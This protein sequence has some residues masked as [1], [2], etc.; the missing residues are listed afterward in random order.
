MVCIPDEI[1]RDRSKNGPLFHALVAAF[2][3]KHESTWRNFD[4]SS[5]KRFDDNVDL[6]KHMESKLLKNNFIKRPVIYFDTSVPS[7]RRPKLENIVTQFGGTLCSDYSSKH[8]HITHVIA[9]DP[10]IDLEEDIQEEERKE[11]DGE[12]ME[13]LYLRT[14]TI[15]GQTYKYNKR[16]RQPNNKNSTALVHWW[17]WPPSYDEWIPADGVEGVNET[18]PPPRPPDGPWTVG[19]KFLRDLLHFNEWGVEAD[20]AIVD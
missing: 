17:F 1:F 14:M 8:H 3:F 11:R 4:L 12:E 19:C 10:E 20:Y 13:K 6:L 18:E 15:I 9:Y 2:E 5:T 16:K 7:H